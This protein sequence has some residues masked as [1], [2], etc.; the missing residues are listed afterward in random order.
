MKIVQAKD[1]QPGDVVPYKH[2]VQVL[3]HLEDCPNHTERVY[4]WYFDQT[5]PICYRRD[6]EVDV[7]KHINI[8]AVRYAAEELSKP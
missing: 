2:G 8:D 6:I 1:L 4:A 7:I 3:S 5:Y